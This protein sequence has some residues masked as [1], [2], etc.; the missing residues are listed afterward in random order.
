VAVYHAGR[1]LV[2]PVVDRGPF[3]RGIS[4]DVSAR[5]ANKLGM[6]STT[7]IRAGY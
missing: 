4:F 7:T 3:S 1:V 6:S 2:L 5:A